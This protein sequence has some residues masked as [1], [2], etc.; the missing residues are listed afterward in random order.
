MRSSQQIEE[1]LPELD[2]L[3]ADD[4]EDQDLDFKRW[5]VSSMEKSV[6]MLKNEEIRQ[7]TRYDRRQVKRLMYE[8]SS[9]QSVRYWSGTRCPLGS[10]I[11]NEMLH[12]MVRGHS[13]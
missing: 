12:R 2:Q 6:Q 3:V 11:L 10:S 8:L 4:L 13:V 7:I 1:L 5:D 9:E